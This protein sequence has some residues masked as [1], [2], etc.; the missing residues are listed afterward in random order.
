VTA[1]GEKLPLLVSLPH[2]GLR[3][4]SEAEPF[5]ILSPHDLEK[6]GDEGAHEIFSALE[7]LVS[8]FVTTD[9]ARAIVDL[10]RTED[11][12]R[13]DGVVKTH[14]CFDVPV[15]DPF[16]PGE[17]VERLLERYYRPYHRR[18][19]EGAGTRVKLGVDCHTMVAVGPPVSPDPGVERP[20]V[21]LSNADGTCTGEW[22]EALCAAFE[23]AFAG[24]RV[25]LNAPFKG[26]HIIRAHAAELPWVQ[27]EISRGPFLTNA[28]K[29]DRVI[30]ALTAWCEATE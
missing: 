19:T 29:R 2:A 9:V 16:P 23:E 6:D 22:F 8:T 20:A 10:N 4:P 14:T 15:Y 1:P 18:L 13:K 30:Q 12:R 28:E 5:C 17:V 27:V 7:A 3:V 25:T 26:G 21:C 24:L 11:D